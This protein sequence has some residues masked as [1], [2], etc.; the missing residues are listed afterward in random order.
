M[1]NTEDIYDEVGSQL[2]KSRGFEFSN[3]LKRKMMGLPGLEAVY[4]MKEFHQLADSAESLKAECDEIFGKLLPGRIEKLPGLESLMAELDQRN[5]PKAV[6]TSSKRE[7]ALMAMSMF[8]LVKK[9]QFVLTAE[10]VTKGKPAPDVYLLAAKNLEILPEN[11]LVLEDSINGSTAAAAAGAVTVA[12]PG[13]HSQGLDFGHVDYVVD[14][15]DS[16][17]ILM[18]LNR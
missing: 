17:V 5:I 8:D 13:L 15:L 4:V 7:F 18:L 3:E 2:L 6:A 9:F 14:R 11:M 10:D 16:E 12:I 1:F